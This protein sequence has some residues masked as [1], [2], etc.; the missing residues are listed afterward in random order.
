MNEKMAV[1]WV[2]M[3]ESFFKRTHNYW[4]TKMTAGDDEGRYS[5]RKRHGEGNKNEPK[6]C[7]WHRLGSRYVTFLYFK[8]ILH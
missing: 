5:E 3:N 1:T 8:F 4:H 2:D 6:R 7:I